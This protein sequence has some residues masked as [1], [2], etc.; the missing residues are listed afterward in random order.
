[1]INF[2]DDVDLLQK[3]NTRCGYPAPRSL[4]TIDGP[5]AR[6]RLFYQ[7]DRTTH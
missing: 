6:R 3:P 4:T 5:F 1:M 7:R 2:T